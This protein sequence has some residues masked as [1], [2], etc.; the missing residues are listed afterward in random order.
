MNALFQEK[1]QNQNVARVET[2]FQIQL[3]K[4]GEAPKKLGPFCSPCFSWMY[5]FN[6]S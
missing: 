3:M 1:E 5:F 2:E 6:K 4:W